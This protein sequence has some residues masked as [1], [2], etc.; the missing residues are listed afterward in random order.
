[1]KRP[2]SLVASLA[3]ALAIAG[4][5]SAAA[6]GKPQLT[7]ACSTKMGSGPKCACFADALEKGLTPEEFATL[8][9]AVEDNSRSAQLL[10]ISLHDDPKMAA[11][12]GEATAACFN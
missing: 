6:A 12:I 2:V 1:M 5:C 10:P 4:A 7:S 3:L 8:A 11:V 9:K